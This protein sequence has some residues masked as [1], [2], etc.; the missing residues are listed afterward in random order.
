M[1]I[2]G[3]KHGGRRQDGYGLVETYNAYGLNGW[4]MVTNVINDHGRGFRS[5]KVVFKRPKAVLWNV[6]IGTLPEK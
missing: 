5:Y 1:G 4:E 2:R 3:I 6:P